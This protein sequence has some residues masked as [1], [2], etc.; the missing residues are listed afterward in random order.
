DADNNVTS[1]TENNGAVSTWTYD[2]NTGYPLTHKDALANKNNTAAATYTYR[3]SL[4]GHIA[5]ITDKVSS[6][7][8]HWHFGYDANGNLTSVQQPNGTAAGSVSTSS[9]SYD[10]VGDLLTTT[11]ANQHTTTYSN[12]D[13]SGYPDTTKDAVG[14]ISTV[15]Y[16]PRG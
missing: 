7:G 6:A 15:A 4:N 10:S 11:D 5:D 13:P 14:N 8:R 2:P 9:L 3:T 12:Y 1:L 16:G